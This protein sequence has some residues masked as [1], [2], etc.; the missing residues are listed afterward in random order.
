MCAIA[1][2]LSWDNANNNNLLKDI[3]HSMVHRGPDAYGN[4]SSGPI[5]LGHQRLSIQDISTAANQPM[6]DLSGRYVIVFNGEIYNFKKLQATLSQHG[7]L[8]KTHS[9]TEVILAAWNHWGIEALSYLEGMF[10]FA[11]WDNA[12]KELYLARDRFGEKPLYYFHLQNGGIVFASEMKALLKHPNCP[13]ELNSA[14]ISQFLSLNYILTE[15][16]I[17]KNVHKLAPAHYMLFRQNQEPLI[18][19]Y[20]SLAE[21]FHAPKWTNSEEELIEQF[22]ALFTDTVKNCSLSDVPLGIFL[23]GG[24]DSSAIATA[25]KNACINESLQAF[26]IGFTE[27][28]YNELDKAKFVAE[29]MHIKHRWE[30]TASENIEKVKSIMGNLDEPFADTSAI[31]MYALSALARKNATVCL[32]GDGGDELFGGYETYR[33]DILHQFFRHL[34]FKKMISAG[35]DLLPVHHHKV[36]FDYKLKQFTKGLCL[37]PQRA[38]YSWRTIFSDSEK[39]SILHNRYKNSVL[40]HDPFDVFSGFY[41]DVERCDLLEQHFYVD[42]KTWMVDDILVKVDRISMMHSLEVRAPFLNHKLAEWII[43]LPTKH[44]IRAM[45]TKYFLKKSLEKALPR[46]ILYSKKEG[47]SSPVSTWLTN[48]AIEQILENP[49][50]NEWFDKTQLYCIWEEHRQKRTDCSYKLFGLF[51]LSSW[52]NNF[53]EKH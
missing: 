23:S 15:Q 51:C 5:S 48:D 6:Q 8:F 34:P 18:K 31:P 29:H 42:L 44:K 16:C 46:S 12:R 20:W 35:V 39:R 14:A 9:D 47:F 19:S 43:R 53:F 36:S 3:T 2:I 26:T 45:R 7:Y 11:L 10:S 21:C 28:S 22:N 37:S 38:H 17:I 49:Y 40:S 50:M 41:G 4:W 1:G 27:N 24:I 52:F 25:V 33:A 30:I 32:S 13:T